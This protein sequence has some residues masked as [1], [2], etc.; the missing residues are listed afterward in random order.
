MATN[1]NLG[2]IADFIKEPYDGTKPESF[3]K[4][5]EDF[6]RPSHICEAVFVNKNLEAPCVLKVLP[7]SKPLNASV[8]FSNTDDDCWR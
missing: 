8:I 1:Q 4:F 3:R 5:M 6:G 2:K 7:E